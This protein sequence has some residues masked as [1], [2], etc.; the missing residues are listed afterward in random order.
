MKNVLSLFMSVTLLLFIFIGSAFSAPPS[1]DDSE[2]AILQDEL[3]DG[4]SI[5]EL[6]IP[7]EAEAAPNEEIFDKGDEFPF[8]E[9]EIVDDK[10]HEEEDEKEKTIL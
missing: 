10:I 2:P 1:M 3:K 7:E 6:I 8:H 5:H 4:E 9:S